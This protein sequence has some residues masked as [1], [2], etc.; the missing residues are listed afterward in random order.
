MKNNVKNENRNLVI[1]MQAIQIEMKDK[2]S[3]SCNLLKDN[4]YKNT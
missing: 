2:E 3:R 1:K 4:N